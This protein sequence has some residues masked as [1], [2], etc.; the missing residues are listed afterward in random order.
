VQ[1]FHHLLDKQ[2]VFMDISSPDKGTLIGENHSGQQ[3]GK[4]VG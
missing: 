1:G 3:R 2:E 4:P